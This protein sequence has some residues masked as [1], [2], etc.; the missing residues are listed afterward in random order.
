MPRIDFVVPGDLATRTGGYIYDRQIVEGLRSRGWRIDVRSLDP[1]FPQPT[2]AGLRDAREC[3]ASL[4]DGSVVVVDGL[5]LAGLER[6]LDAH[7]RRLC[8]VGLVHHP[9]GLETGLDE[10]TARLLEA[11]ESRALGFTRRVI[12][13]SQWTAR[14]LARTG[15]PVERLR[16]AEPGIDERAAAHPEDA[17][18]GNAASADA[19][20]VQLLCVATLTPRKGHAVLL[21]ALG[22]LRD[23]RWHLSCAGSLTRD[24]DH[25]AALQHRIERLR[26]GPRVSL[27]GEVD[28]EALERYYR[29]ADLFVLPS[30]LEGY[31][32]ALADALARGIPILSTTA[33]AI[34]ETV[35]AAASVLVPPGDSRALGKALATLVDDANARAS[36]AAHARAARAALPTWTS[37]VDKFAA[38]L[39][40]TEAWT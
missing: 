28:E 2:P 20:T 26:L 37:A 7:A 4:R 22:D 24:P 39:D 25:V 5:A 30:F 18:H 29:R 15:V 23:R 34:P 14:T 32:M 13:T 36:L 21:D 40:G 11:A 3:F 10:T 6:V 38:A 35:P 17:P 27:L 33:G 12:V 9:V 16:V 1:S 8:L 31:G 19:A